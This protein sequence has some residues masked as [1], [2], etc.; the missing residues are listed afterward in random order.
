[1]V[2]DAENTFFWKEKVTGQTGTSEVIKTGKGD[3][4]N[5]LTLVVKTPGVT[6]DLTVTLETADNEKMTGAKT[7]GTYTAVKGKTLA[8]KV[9]Y[10]DLGYLRLK[11][12]AAAAQ[13][14]GAI[15]AALV[16][17]ADIA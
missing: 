3:A 12:S 2:Y 13:S 5:P 9:P 15:T 8:V 17:D 6:A 11:W 10:G 1:M 4:G 14:A 7:L 16:L